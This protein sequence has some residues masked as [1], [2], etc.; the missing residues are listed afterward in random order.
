[1]KHLVRDLA[2]GYGRILAGT[3]RARVCFRNTDV[4]AQG[5]CLCDAEQRG[6]LT[7]AGYDESAVV[8]V[9]R[10]DDAGKGRDDFLEALQLLQSLYV[11]LRRIYISLARIQ[12]RL[13]LIELLCGDDFLIHQFLPARQCC[14][15]EFGVGDSLLGGGTRLT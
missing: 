8:D 15:R 13:L 7:A 2:E 3:D 10:G 14:T 12:G 6:A 9:A 4:D 11:G 1:M 5:I